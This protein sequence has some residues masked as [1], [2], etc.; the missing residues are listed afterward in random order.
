MGVRVVAA[1][2]FEPLRRRADLFFQI[3]AG[4]ADTGQRNVRLP[5]PFVDLPQLFPRDSAFHGTRRGRVVGAAADR[6]RR[7][8]LKVLCQLAAQD[9]QVQCRRPGA[10]FQASMVAPLTAAAF[11]LLPGKLLA[12]F[13]R[14]LRQRLPLLEQL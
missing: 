3:F 12:G 7:P 5:Q 9:L 14:F 11:Q 8:V 10:F 13:F 6:A 1:R 2:L 4:G